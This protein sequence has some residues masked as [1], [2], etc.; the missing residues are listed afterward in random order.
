MLATMAKDTLL[1]L[2]FAMQIEFGLILLFFVAMGLGL[3]SK[4]SRY[5]QVRIFIG[6]VTITAITLLVFI[7]V[8]YSN[9]MIRQ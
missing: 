4:I 5:W 6:L 8:A 3:R 2:L 9:G 1:A 7:Y